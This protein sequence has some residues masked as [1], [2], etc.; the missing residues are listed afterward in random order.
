MNLFREPDI[1]KEIDTK[2]DTMR[3]THFTILRIVLLSF[4]LGGCREAAFP[5]PDI[6]EMPVEM[7]YTLSWDGVLEIRGSGELQ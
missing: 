6:R 3:R 2:G 1:I 7:S 4:V 5:E